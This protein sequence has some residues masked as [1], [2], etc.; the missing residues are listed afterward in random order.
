MLDSRLI[1]KYDI[2]V[3]QRLRCYEKHK[4]SIPNCCFCM[5]QNHHFQNYTIITCHA[6]YSIKN[7]WQK[8]CP[9]VFTKWYWAVHSKVV[10]LGKHAHTKQKSHSHTTS[11]VSYQ[12]YMHALLGQRLQ[13][14]FS[15]Y[16]LV[17]SNISNS[18]D[19]EEKN[20]VKIYW[21]YITEEDKPVE[22]TQTVQNV[23]FFS[24][25]SNLVAVHFVWY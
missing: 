25:P 9:I 4:N 22:F 6:Y 12:V 8:M 2:F 13:S 10:R 20:L 16:G 14:I 18:L 21:F 5:M 19:T 15:R 17:W 23:I 1:S 3:H 7:W 24:S 11:A